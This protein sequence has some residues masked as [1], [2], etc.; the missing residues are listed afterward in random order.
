MAKASSGLICDMRSSV[1]V[2]VLTNEYQIVPNDVVSVTFSL[3]VAAD[4]LG[5]MFHFES[6]VSHEWERRAVLRDFRAGRVRREELC[7]A[8]FLL[9]AAGRHHGVDSVRPCPICENVM[10]DVLW[11][12]G[13]N[14]GRRSGTARSA[15]EIDSIV[16]QAGP[17]TVHRVEVCD[18]CGWNHLLTESQAVPDL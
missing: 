11:I 3:P 10:R 15:E 2:V 13:D 6:E 18:R 7:D 14:V 5:A 12:Y 4:R 1:E 17:V 8:D 9:K 16:A